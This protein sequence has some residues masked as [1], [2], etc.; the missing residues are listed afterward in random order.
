MYL[1]RENMVSTA[2]GVTRILFICP[3]RDSAGVARLSTPR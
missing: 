3:L 1:R 2:K